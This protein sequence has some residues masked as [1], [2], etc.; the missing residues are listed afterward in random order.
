MRAPAPVD[1]ARGQLEWLVTV[2]AVKRFTERTEGGRVLFSLRTA[3]L[4]ERTLSVEQVATFRAG[5][6][7]GWWLPRS[8]VPR[9]DV[10][11]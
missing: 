7:V 3:D 2:G 1:V 6:L 11:G 9:S 10:D 5:V 4:R 8:D